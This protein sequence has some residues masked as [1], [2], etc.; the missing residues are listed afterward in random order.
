MFANSGGD[1]LLVAKNLDWYSGQG[2]ILINKRSVEKQAILVD[3]QRPLRWTSRYASLTF[4][5]NGQEF[6]WEGMNEAGLSVNSLLQLDP[7]PVVSAASVALPSVG[8]VQWIQYILDTSASLSEAIANA[9]RVRIGAGLTLHYFVCDASANCASFEQINGELVIHSGRRLPVPALTNTGYADSLAQF[10]TQASTEEILGSRRSN[11]SLQRFD[12]AAVWSSPARSSSSGDAVS[13]AF[14]GL[15]DLAQEVP[16]SA[17][18]PLALRTFWNLVFDLPSKTVYWRTLGSPE[19]KFVS[20]AAFDTS[21]A[22]GLPWLDLSAEGSG[23][24]SAHFTQY[25]DALNRHAVELWARSLPP[26]PEFWVSAELRRALKGY[27]STT[28][29]L[30]EAR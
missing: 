22:S 6:P 24:M 17:T 20:L 16:A 30:D 4:S 25:S 7:Y 27:P 29:C 18:A 8:Y 15:Q 13:F 28:R 10:D 26:L 19:V 2:R 21:C 1:R 9:K 11:S 3:T 5:G 14:R 12:R 23:D